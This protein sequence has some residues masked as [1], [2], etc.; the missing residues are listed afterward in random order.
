MYRGLELHPFEGIVDLQDKMK[1]IISH[2]KIDA[3]IM[4]RL[5]QIGLWRKFMIKMVMF[6]I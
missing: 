6:L 1:S 2:E 5:D 3:V 4:A